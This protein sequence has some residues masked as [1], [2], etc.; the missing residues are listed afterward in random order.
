MTD[1]FFSFIS[2]VLLLIK[3]LTWLL[4]VW[5]RKRKCQMFSLTSHRKLSD[6]YVISLVFYLFNLFTKILSV[7][8]K[9]KGDFF[10]PVKEVITRFILF[11]SFLIFILSTDSMRD[12]M[13]CG[14]HRF[15]SELALRPR[16]PPI[17]PSA[18]WYNIREITRLCGLNIR[19][20]NSRNVSLCKIHRDKKGRSKKKNREV[21]M[22]LKNTI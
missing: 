13:G 14:L 4:C 3:S 6:I 15:D 1:L 18:R 11:W 16:C 5:E 7:I 2:V 22:I 12:L 10:F 19:N 9:R 21:F 20:I 8:N 17:R